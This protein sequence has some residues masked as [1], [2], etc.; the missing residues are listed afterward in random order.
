MDEELHGTAV[1]LLFMMQLT[2]AM[3]GT[4]MSSSLPCVVAVLWGQL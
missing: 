1:G 3:Q 4:V 2:W